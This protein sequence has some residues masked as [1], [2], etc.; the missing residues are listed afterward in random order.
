[1]SELDFFNNTIEAERAVLGAIIVSNNAREEIVSMLEEEDFLQKSHQII[2][3]AVYDL[4]SIGSEV[5]I[6]SIVSYLDTSMKA[7]DTI[8]GIEYIYQ[9]SESYIGDTNAFYH[10]RIIKD[11]SLSRKLINTMQKCIDG[12]K[13]EKIKD[14]S[15][16]IAECENKILAV[17]QSRR[18]AEFV[19]AQEVVS[20][21]TN[22]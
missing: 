3:R 8:G 15:Q 2:Y 9:L 11:A 5:D 19:T 10:V 17:T 4:L 18:V 16:Y 1:M 12:F 20:K 13:T 21:V 7:L 14:V 22:K 6:P